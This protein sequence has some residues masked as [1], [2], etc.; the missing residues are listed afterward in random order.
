LNEEVVAVH[1]AVVAVHRA[2]VAVHGAVVHRAVVG[3]HGAVGALNH[4]AKQLAADARAV[5]CC[6]LER[7]ASQVLGGFSGED[8]DLVPETVSC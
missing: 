6:P 1:G 3:V 2:V 4:F 5:A 7:T 8:P